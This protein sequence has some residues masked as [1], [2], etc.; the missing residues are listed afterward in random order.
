MTYLGKSYSGLAYLGQAFLGQ[1]YLA[2]RWCLLFCFFFLF[3]LF[4]PFFFFFFCFCP[5][6]P[7]PNPQNPPEPLKPP[8]LQNL[9]PEHLNSTVNRPSCGGDAPQENLMKPETRHKPCFYEGVAFT[10]KHGLH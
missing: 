6:T 8:E 2:D 10:H 1:A 3:L 9:N 7:L 4:S 5:Q